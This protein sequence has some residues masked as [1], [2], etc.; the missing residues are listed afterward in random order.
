MDCGRDLP[1]SRR[2]IAHWMMR[3]MVHRL[4]CMVALIGA[5]HL[6]PFDLDLNV[7]VPG[8]GDFLDNGP[9]FKSD[10]GPAGLRPRRA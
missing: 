7:R 8:T 1:M 5:V 3:R 6:M 9:F 10:F 4:E 2:V